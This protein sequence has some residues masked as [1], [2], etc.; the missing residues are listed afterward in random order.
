MKKLTRGAFCT[1]IHF[2]RKQ[3]SSQH[4]EDCIHFLQWFVKQAAENNCDYIGFLGDWN[5]NRTALN[6]STL[7]FSYVGAKI[8]NDT[9][10]PVFFCVGNHDLYQRHTREIYSVVPFKEFTNFTVIDHPTVIKH[11]GD[12]ALFS[13]FLFHDEYPK[14]KEFKKLPFWGGHFEFNGFI[15]TGYSH[16]M[17]NGADPLLCKGPDHILSGHFHKRQSQGNIHYIGNCFPMDYG[18]SG[19]TDRGMVVY[20]HDT[21]TPTYI[22]WNECPKY[23]RVKLSELLENGVD[24]PNDARVTCVPD[25]DI[26]YEENMELKK[27]FAEKYGLREF[28]LDERALYDDALTATESNVD[29]SKLDSIDELVVQML[30]EIVDEQIDNKLLIQ[31]YKDIQ[32]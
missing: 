23:V 17:E 8:L 12:G 16:K 13:P 21:R 26:T 31:Q 3:N 28:V 22:N 9:G 10:L 2:G 7:N 20:D 6:I 32:V 5:E 15:L 4:N 19:D 11:I 24:L 27:T 25:V 30:G 1:D 18:D 29:C 14:L